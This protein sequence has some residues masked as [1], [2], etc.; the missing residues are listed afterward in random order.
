MKNVLVLTVAIIGI[1][2]ITGCQECCS[3]DDNK[4]SCPQDASLK[5]LVEL[6]DTEIAKLKKEVNTL[7]AKLEVGKKQSKQS[8]NMMMDAFK[9]I[10]IEND[11][12]KKEIEKLRLNK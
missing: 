6:K 3:C 8:A 10:K 12:L 11:K 1:F 9:Q 2:L 7:E 4:V 5:R